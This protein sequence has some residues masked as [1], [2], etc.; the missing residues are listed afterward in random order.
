MNRTALRLISLFAILALFSVWA[1]GQAETGLINGTVTDKTGAV[2][3]GAT[4]TATS[5]DTGL[6]RSTTTKSGR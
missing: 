6:V 5:T 2:V 4:V 3:V 1:F